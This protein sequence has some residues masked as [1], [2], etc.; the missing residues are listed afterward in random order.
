MYNQF[1]KKNIFLLK[2]VFSYIF[3]LVLILVFYK[4]YFDF[5]L[6]NIDVTL[7]KKNIQKKNNWLLHIDSNQIS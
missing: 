2:D 3:V 7:K 6:C 1:N 5:G 4:F